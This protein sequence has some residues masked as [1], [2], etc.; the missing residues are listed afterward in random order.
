MRIEYIILVCNF[1]LTYLTKTENL[2]SNYQMPGDSCS[3]NH[4]SIL[5]LVKTHPMD[6]G[7]CKFV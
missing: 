1:A 4:I 3:D 7:S 5:I 2:H 6:L